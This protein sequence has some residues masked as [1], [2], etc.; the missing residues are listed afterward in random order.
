MSTTPA[1]SSGM[2]YARYG[3][4][5][6]AVGI[7]IFTYM[8]GGSGEYPLVGK[9]APKIS[10][11]TLDGAPLPVGDE[12]GKQVVVLNFWATWCPPCREELPEFSKLATQ[13]PGK[14]VSFYSVC[15]DE[16][17]DLI[18]SVVNETTP[19]PPAAYDEG[20]AAATAYQVSFLPTTVLVA[21]DGVIHSAHIGYS[22]AMLEELRGD[23]NTL[24]ASA[25]AK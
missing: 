22:A 3:L 23:I 9:P 16:E 13:F 4:L 7:L 10:L 19:K 15:I 8:R 1:S 20:G 18:A 12:L 2:T 14:P 24:L 5:A 11:A 25:P 17:K 21:P 6:L